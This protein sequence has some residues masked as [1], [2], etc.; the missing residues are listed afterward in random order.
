V[1]YV[2]FSSCFLEGANMATFANEDQSFEYHVQLEQISKI[3]LIE[4]ET[5]NKKVLRI[6]RL[7]NATGDSMSS[8]ILADSSEAAKVWYHDL[9]QRR[10]NEIVL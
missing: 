6:I 9:V 8:F 3:M 2:S 1:V 10:G 7:L 4:K 5:P